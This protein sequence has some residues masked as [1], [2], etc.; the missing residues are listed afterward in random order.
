MA[1]QTKATEP[2][3]TMRS[4][5]QLPTEPAHHKRR[6]VKFNV[7]CAPLD[8]R[9][10]NPLYNAKYD[11]DTSKLACTDS[12]SYLTG[13]PYVLIDADT[14]AELARANFQAYTKVSVW[15]DGTRN[16]HALTPITIRDDVKKIAL[17][18]ANDSY[19]SR[20]QYPLFP[21]DL[22]DSASTT[23]N[24]FEIRTDLVLDF[25]DV[26]TLGAAPD[27]NS[28]KKAPSHTDEYF[29]FLTGDMWRKISHEF[30]N[31]VGT[32]CPIESISR[33]LLKGHPA[34]IPP[35]SSLANVSSTR[36]AQ[37]PRLPDQSENPQTHS[38]PV[39]GP[40]ASGTPTTPRGGTGA[41]PQLS[42]K[43][44]VETLSNVDWT[45]VLSPI[46][47]AGA[48]SR[49]LDAFEVHI[50]LLQIKLTFAE[51][52]FANAI[53]SSNDTNVRD[54]IRRTSPGTFAAILK[55][56]WRCTLIRWH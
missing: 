3:A 2:I 56:M 12:A 27:T 41:P 50:P 20:R 39:T 5:T 44:G 52:S 28:L 40:Y 8:E 15:R 55:A 9:G 14:K 36:P 24:I 23:I 45:A 32:L 30:H 46:Y 31:E 54:A 37:I 19:R 13:S 11:G 33:P 42:T 4:G 47:E 35:E 22:P 53:N 49:S 7:Y 29:G 21:F 51:R 38:G 17:F 43:D 25:C 10:A 6:V 1:T 26:N 18:I 34:H 16:L 48:G